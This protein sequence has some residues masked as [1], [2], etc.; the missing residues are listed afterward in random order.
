[1]P[2]APDH[3]P[4]PD[5]CDVGELRKALHAHIEDMFTRAETGLDIHA[6]CLVLAGKLI[7]LAKPYIDLFIAHELS[8]PRAA[9]RPDS[10]A[11]SDRAR[12]DVKALVYGAGGKTAGS[13]TEVG[14]VGAHTIVQLLA[15]FTSD[16][17]LK[18]LATALGQLRLGQVHPWLNPP[19]IGVH[20]KKH[21]SD[22]LRLKS[23][24]L[25]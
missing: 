6:Q 5:S 3:P 1:M 2:E 20:P 12:Q 17:Y 21:A 7:E 13:T 19:N 4:P 11:A 24:P 9:K 23:I 18:V 22:A 14:L 25:V 15:V 8:A 10:L 16:P